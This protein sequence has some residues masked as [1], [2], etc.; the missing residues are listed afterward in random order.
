M[1]TMGETLEK[2]YPQ[3]PTKALKLREFSRA[4]ELREC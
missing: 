2:L 1:R 4:E 3:P